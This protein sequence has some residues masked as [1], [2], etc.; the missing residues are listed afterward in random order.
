[1]AAQDMIVQDM[2][3]Q[4]KTEPKTSEQKEYRRTLII[5]DNTMNL[6]ATKLIFT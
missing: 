3:V 5:D 2:V 1:M 4:D 6:K